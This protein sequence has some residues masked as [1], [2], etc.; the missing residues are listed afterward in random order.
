[1]ST[2]DILFNVTVL[3]IS[4]FLDLFSTWYGS[5]NFDM[6]VNSWM[7]KVGW[8]R[9]ILINIVLVPVLSIIVQ[10]RSIFAAVLF[11]LCALRNFQIGTMAR[12]MGEEAYLATYRQFL[13]SSA[14]YFPLIPIFFE[15]FIY[16]A[17]GIAIIISTGKPKN[18]NQEYIDTIGLA[19]S[20]VGLNISFIAIGQRIEKKYAKGG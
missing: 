20:I 12:A 15:S 16:I 4:R 5:P 13:K 6:E 2:E 7:K 9:V 1:M 17:I 14:W 8:R 18:L 3:G 10:K 11:S 19:L